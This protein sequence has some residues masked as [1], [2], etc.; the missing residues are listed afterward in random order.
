[1]SSSVLV[2]M[3]SSAARKVRSVEFRASAAAFEVMLDW[4][5]G[6]RDGKK[7]CLRDTSAFRSGCLCVQLR[8]L[9][10]VTRLAP[11]HTGRAG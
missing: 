11:P 3:C 9:V 8:L 6:S 2:V 1:M 4:K 7:G 10:N 5:R